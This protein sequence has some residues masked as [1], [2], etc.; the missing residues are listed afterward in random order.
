MGIAVVVSTL[1]FFAKSPS[2][3]EHQTLVTVFIAFLLGLVFWGARLGVLP[4][5]AAVGY[6]LRLF[7]QQVT[8]P[9]FSL[10]LIVMGMMAM[11]PVAL[12]FQLVVSLLIDPPSALSGGLAPRDH[13]LLIVM[14]APFSLASNILLNAS[15]AYALKQ[16]LHPTIRKA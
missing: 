14:S 11:F 4:I 1:M 2:P 9:L 10:Q 12:V 15:A 13:F 8:S 6:P 7:L 3:A 5:L 16:L